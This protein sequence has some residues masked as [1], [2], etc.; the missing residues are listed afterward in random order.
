M[1]ASLSIVNVCHILWLRKMGFWFGVAVLFVIYLLILLT[2]RIAFFL[3]ADGEV[4]AFWREAAF[5]RWN[6]ILP[7]SRTPAA[8]RLFVGLE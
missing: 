7:K 5:T 3:D 4:P 2:W 6:W 8:Q 1:E